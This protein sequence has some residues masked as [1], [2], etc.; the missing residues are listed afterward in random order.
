MLQMLLCYCTCL[1]LLYP[2]AELTPSSLYNAILCVY[3]WTK[4]CKT[5]FYANQNQTYAEVA[6]LL[7]Y[8]IKFN[9]KSQKYTMQ[10]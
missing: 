8:E 5:I 9:S 4:E 1:Q 10:I 3:T 7:L 2:L 6:T